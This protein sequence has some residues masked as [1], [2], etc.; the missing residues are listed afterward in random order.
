MECPLCAAAHEA[1]ESCA[2]AEEGSRIGQVV[3][4]KYRI[5]RR[6]ARGGM[7]TVYEASHIEIG[8]PFALKVLHTELKDHATVR[9]R[10]K[11]EAK[12]AGALENDHVAA[13]L[14]FGMLPDET[15]YIVMELLRGED[16][17]TRLARE[18]TI[19]PEEA[20]EIVIQMCAGLQAAHEAKVIHRDLKPG[21]VFL[22][23]RDG[24]RP[25]VKL[26]DFGVAR[27]LSSVPSENT[28][29]G[30]TMGTPWYM[31]P[32]QAR[33]QRDLDS[34]SDVYG[35]GVVLFEMLSGE[36]P[37]LAEN[38]NALLHQIATG[39]APSLASRCPELSEKLCAVVDRA[40]APEP[41]ERFASA[42]EFANA[43]APFIRSAR[44]PR[45]D[46][47]PT[48]AT[49]ALA[50]PAADAPL[51]GTPTSD[52][53]VPSAPVADTTTSN[54][55]VDEG[56]VSTPALT[57]PDSEAT[58][59]PVPAG[60]ADLRASIPITK[61]G[62][63]VWITLSAVAFILVVFVVS[64]FRSSD[65]PLA[66]PTAS[67]AP[68]ATPVASFLE[69]LD[70][71]PESST[72]LPSES[73]VASTAEAPLAAAAASSAPANTDAASSAA[74]SSAPASSAA[75]SSVAVAASPSAASST[76]R[77]VAFPA[78]GGTRSGSA[79]VSGSGTISVNAIP[80]AEVFIDGRA[81]GTT[82]MVSLPIAPGTHTVVVAHPERGRL[83][84]V[85]EVLPGESEVVAFRFDEQ[86][87]PA[88]APSVTATAAATPSA[89][90]IDC[91]PDY[92]V[93]RD[94][95]RRLKPECLQRTSNPY[96]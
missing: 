68:T 40:L 25:H 38:T 48:P 31:S 65:E 56:A 58:T 42:L 20:I 36:K 88:A 35:L 90:V 1:H 27:A 16:L 71:A 5:V 73:V 95:I 37:H 89:P 86:R 15:L 96:R 75:A 4:G 81:F 7:A 92:W 60:D 78:G 47:A 61:T 11:H 39:R 30:A 19:P 3:A 51:P 29:I 18:G 22:C 85:V 44:E 53:A 24:A 28:E 83:A 13:V 84:R 45:A 80:R 79:A 69:R 9:S 23:R 77:T 50:P 43:L 33:G 55:P 63:G 21:N 70:P 76:A 91:T 49:L 72:A 64:L 57:Q 26:L 87:A 93:D 14:D 46:K 12:A 34:R 17:A 66:E 8:R 74:V 52:A 94:G 32:E 2:S 67:T 54:T 59:T 6:V 10:F 82:P 41:S 62:R